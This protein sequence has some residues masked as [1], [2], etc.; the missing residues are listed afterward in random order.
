ME[1]NNGKVDDKITEVLKRLCGY[2][3]VYVPEFTWGDLRIDAIVLDMDKRWIRGFEV[4]Q[5]RADFLQDRKWTSYTQFCS[6]L[7]IVCPEG[8]I[9]PEEVEKPFGLLYVVEEFGSA[10]GRWKKR[11]QVFQ[12]RQS[13][14]WFWTYTRVLETEFPR[15]LAE[16]DQAESELKWYKKMEAERGFRPTALN[17]KKNV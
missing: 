3:G 10:Y 4:K 15:I 5:S 9:R 6:S 11:P 8:L 16:K 13:L 1:N 14:S 17:P 2:R 7:S 12:K